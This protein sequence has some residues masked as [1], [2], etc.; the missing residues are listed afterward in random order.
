MTKRAFSRSPTGLI[1]LFQLARSFLPAFFESRKR[2]VRNDESSRRTTC[3]DEI[4]L[5]NWKDGVEDITL[6]VQGNGVLLVDGYTSLRRT[7]PKQKRQRKN[8]RE[9]RRRA[10][11][12]SCFL[13]QDEQTR[14][15]KK[16]LNERCLR[17]VW[18]F[19]VISIYSVSLCLYPCD[20]HSDRKGTER[21]LWRL[22]H[23]S[24]TRSLRS[25]FR[26]VSFPFLSSP[27]LSFPS[28]LRPSLPSF[29]PPPTPLSHSPAH[30]FVSFRFVS[31]ARSFAL[32][33]I[34]SRIKRND[35]AGSV[36]LPRQPHDFPLF[37]IPIQRES[38]ATNRVLPS[39]DRPI[40]G[41]LSPIKQ[42]V[43]S[44]CANSLAESRYANDG[45]RRETR[46]K[47]KRSAYKFENDNDDR[48]ELRVA[49][50]QLRVAGCGLRVMGYG[51]WV[52]VTGKEAKVHGI[53]YA[54]NIRS[55]DVFNSNVVV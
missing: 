2:Q 55:F 21:S 36:H 31:R 5:G 23:R 4:R 3:F 49:G 20:A 50:C 11:A 45:K 13:F 34:I 46:E 17:T 14:M 22:K 42:D 15:Q 27:F 43:E 25:F 12:Y 39:I 28:P 16:S 7:V 35:I 48:F 19:S 18:S 32:R 29:T 26:F 9:R 10:C 44:R 52:I 33:V 47:E 53:Q 37:F 41:R 30:R 1:R 24:V 40:A 38:S 54:I 8:E 51:L 6:L